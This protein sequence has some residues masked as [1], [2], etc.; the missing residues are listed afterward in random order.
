[1]S[2]IKLFSVYYSL[3]NLNYKKTIKT[4]VIEPIQTGKDYT[5]FDLAML[6]DNEGDNI[7]RKNPYY[8][9]MTC[10]YWVWKN[11]IKTH[12]DVEYIGFTQ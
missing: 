12:P 8:G 1:M 6:S 7:S 5:N 4:D 11:Y 3:S 10:W 2:K 9:E